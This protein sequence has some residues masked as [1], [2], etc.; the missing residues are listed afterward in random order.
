MFYGLLCRTLCIFNDKY[1]GY[2]TFNAIIIG[3]LKHC[4]CSWYIEK[5][6]FTDL[7]SSNL[8]WLSNSNNLLM[9]F[10]WVCTFT[11][12]PCVNS[13][14]NITHFSPMWILLF[15]LPYLNEEDLQCSVNGIC[16][17]GHSCLISHLSGKILNI[18]LFSVMFVN[19]FFG[20]IFLLD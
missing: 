18:I 2:L 20:T 17:S 4:F 5:N 13:S 11:V 12:L 8:V 3:I 16:D 10:F 15:F 9:C 1:F 7:V 19:S 6:L 14:N